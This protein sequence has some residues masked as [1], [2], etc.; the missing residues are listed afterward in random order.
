MKKCIEIEYRFEGECEQ[1]DVHKVVLDAMSLQSIVAADDGFP[2][3]I[4]L[5]FHQCP[6]CSLDPTLEPH[7]PAAVNMVSLVRQFDGTRS[8]DNTSVVVVTAERKTCSHTTVQRGLCSLIGLL[9][10]T[11]GCPL[12]TFFKPMARFHLPFANIAETM[13]RSTSMYVMTQYFKN[14]SGG[15]LDFKFEGLHVIYNQVHIVNKAFA[16]RLRAG[17]EQ[18]AIVNCIILLD[19]FAKTMPEAIT[20]SLAEFRHLFGSYLNSTLNTNT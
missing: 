14:H 5:A 20:A 3:W 11:S 2:D 12:T 9:M 7:C 17:C 15:S 16:R 19:K 1:E 18:D 8:Y 6:N 13:W 4:D 10:A